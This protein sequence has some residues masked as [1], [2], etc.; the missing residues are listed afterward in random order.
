MRFNGRF[1]VESGACLAAIVGAIM[2]LAWLLPLPGLYAT[3]MFVAMSAATLVWMLWRQIRRTN[4]AVA[5]FVAALDRGDLAQAFPRSGQGTGF[6]TLAAS[7]DAALHRRREERAIDAA[8]YRF[9]TA[10]VDEA[11]TPLLAIDPFG[12]VQLSNKRART[13]FGG[14]EGR[15]IAEFARYG[16]GFATALA[17][18]EPGE[19]RMC[20]VTVAG[21]SERATLSCTGIERNGAA[22]RL[23]SV[24]VIQSELDAAEIATQSDLVRV[25]THEIMNSVTPVTSLAAS[26]AELMAAIDDGSDATVTDARLAVEA[27][28]RRAAGIMRFVESYRQFSTIPSITVARFAARPWLDE[29]ARLHAA[30]PQGAAAALTTVVRPYVL[31]IAADRDLL[32]QVL[33]NLLKNGA[34]AAI[35]TQATPSIAVAIDHAAGGRTRIIVDDN[36]PGIPDKAAADIFLPF[37]TTKRDGNGVGLS[38][39]RQIVL[40]HN[41]AIEVGRN[42]AG[43]ARFEMIL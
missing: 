4:L 43:G 29:L 6:D 32:S 3:K 35:A 16:Q 31:E 9:A 27:L 34:E 17:G 22:W 30:T 5:S 1:V 25:L 26:A 39:A 24:D 12:V 8:D 40:L 15:R 36:G 37:F 13:M 23:V 42:E 11:P 41:G 18:L 33:L 28:S 10:L 20:R 14:T 2:L 21:R 19:R 38:F 7:F